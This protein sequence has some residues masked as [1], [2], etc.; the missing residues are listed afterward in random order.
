MTQSESRALVAYD[1]VTD[2]LAFINEMGI[3]IAK[4]GMFG[5]SNVDQGK[6]FAMACLAKRCDPL[7]LAERYH[8][9]QGKLSMKADAMLAGLHERGGKHRIIQRTAEGADIE[10]SHEGQTQRFTLTWDEAQQEKFVWGKPDKQGKQE[11]KDNYATPRSRM[12]MLWARVVSDGVRAMCPG[13]VVGTYTPEEI[14]DFTDSEGDSTVVHPVDTEQLMKEA[15]ARK[16]PDDVQDAEFEPTSE[17]HPAALNLSTTAQRQYLNDLC[18]KLNVALETREGWLKKRGL[19]SFRD[20][21]AEDISEIIAKLKVKAEQ[22]GKAETPY[23]EA[24]DALA[25]ADQIREVKDLLTA[26]EPKAPGT[27]GKI[28]AKVQQLGKQK[29]AELNRQQVQKIIDAL[30]AKHKQLFFDQSL[31]TAPS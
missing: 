31:Q 19:A 3:S 15:A 17:D 29:I 14:Q 28:Q 24:V 30:D 6:V 5:C 22:N 23:S 2:P 21:K 4:S 25:T 1:R 7:S 16:Q 10:I 12:Q 18:D 9:I 27:Y 11:I 26:I 20:M 8:L 13:V